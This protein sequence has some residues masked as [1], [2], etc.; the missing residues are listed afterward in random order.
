MSAKHRQLRHRCKACDRNFSSR[1]LLDDHLWE[2]HQDV[3]DPEAACFADY[4]DLVLC[5]SSADSFFRT[6]SP[7]VCDPL[8][9][10]HR[11]V[12][13]T[14][15]VD[16]CFE[17][18]ERAS[19]RA[20]LCDHLHCAA[21][22]Y[23]EGRYEEDAARWS[24]WDAFKYGALAIVTSLVLVMYL[25]VCMWQKEL[26]IANDLRRLS[27]SRHAWIGTSKQKDS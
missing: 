11:H 10:E 2:E 14:K 1:L 22:E 9:L 23:T 19:F 12:Q 7:S 21:R 13:C 16:G 26:S 6:L 5:P 17:P 3:L 4:C 8:S 25:G 20:R 15:I 27:S 18:E 24:S